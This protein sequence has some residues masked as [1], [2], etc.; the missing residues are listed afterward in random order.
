MLRHMLPDLVDILID[1]VR[2]TQVPVFAHLLLCGDN[3]D[4]LA[5]LAAQVAPAAVDVLDQ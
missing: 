1:A 2:C 5:E 3:L 4:E